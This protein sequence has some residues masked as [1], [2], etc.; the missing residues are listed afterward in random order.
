MKIS[1]NK[2][3]TVALAYVGVIIG[4]GFASGQE[5]MQY[6]VSYGAM[7][8]WGLV[9]S[10]IVFVIG[11][12]VLLQFGSYY[13]AREHSDVIDQIA[14]PYIS[15]IID[16]FINISLFLF[17]FV[18]IAGAGSSL[19]Q[20]FG[21][22]AWIGSLILTIFLYLSSFLNVN[23]V[24]N[25]ISM[26]TP[27][28]VVFVIISAFYVLLAVD[29]N[30]SEAL[31]VSGSQPDILPNW[32]ISAI[33]Y[34]STALMVAISMGFLIGGDEYSPKQAGIS[35]GLGG[36]IVTLLLFISY[37]AL[38][39]G[40]EEV[41]GSEMPMLAMID[42]I[43]PFLG[44]VMSLIIFGMVYNTAIGLYY[45]LAKRVTKERPKRFNMAMFFLLLFGFI[46]SFFGFETLIATILSH[47][48]LSRHV[49][50]WINSCTVV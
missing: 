8:F 15:K 24:T 4:A 31:Q 40:I 26:I 6:Y 17:G 48:W 35:G 23:K 38:T 44:G 29:F 39:A 7:G 11:G 2:V 13:L 33:N 32:F 45:P 30:F 18:M 37:F 20:Q 19:N 16:L 25:V 47:H 9:I 36:L 10:G 28:V 22:P 3:I 49:S 46:L 21:L 14:S 12:V 41:I 50:H 43:H 27:F 42:A 1:W 34:C 5:I